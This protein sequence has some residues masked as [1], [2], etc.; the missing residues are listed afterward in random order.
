[1]RQSGFVETPH[2]V[3]VG[4]LRGRRGAS[5]T[6]ASAA[7]DSDCHMRASPDWHATTFT[8]AEEAVAAGRYACD[9]RGVP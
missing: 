3:V 8:T 2:A 6:A 9:W 4:M 7:Q 5:K 1:M